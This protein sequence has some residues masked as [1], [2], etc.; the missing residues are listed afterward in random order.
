M[1][2]NLDPIGLGQTVPVVTA[3]TEKKRWSIME[4]NPRYTPAQRLAAR[5]RYLKVL[6]D[7]MAN[8]NALDY[9]AILENTKKELIRRGIEPDVANELASESLQEL[10]IGVS[11]MKN[12][13]KF[14]RRLVEEG[15]RELEVSSGE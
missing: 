3:Q 10:R 5:E 2:K 4:G 15:R 1:K 8:I 9:N 7:V 14:L 11:A 12:E 6:E 13:Y